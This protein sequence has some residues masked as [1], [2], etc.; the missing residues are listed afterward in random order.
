MLFVGSMWYGPN[1]RAADWLVQE[2]WPL[3]R[4]R[5]PAATLLIAGAA[6]PDV[7]ARWERQPGV[8]APGFVQDLR[9]AYECAGVVVVPV[10]EGGGSPIKLLE[11]LAHARP[12]VATSYAI[13][14]FDPELKD[15]RHLLAADR[16][17]DFSAQL[18]HLLEDPG[19]A[20]KMGLDGRAAVSEHFSG[21]RFDAIVAQ[22][23]ADVFE[24][25]QGP[26]G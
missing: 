12:M 11:A 8:S 23:L 3:V 14:P 9:Q 7:R 17:E 25:I 1:A 19:Q 4:R 22:T 20:R 10:R 24:P 15:G 2:I 5:R 26:V 13:A 6:P 18:I 21:A 16:S